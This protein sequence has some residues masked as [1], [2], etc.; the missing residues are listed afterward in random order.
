MEKL[1]H[2]HTENYSQT[3]IGENAV[4]MIYVSVELDLQ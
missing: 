3:E 2:T 1:K 4:Q